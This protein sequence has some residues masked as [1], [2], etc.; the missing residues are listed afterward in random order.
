L[1]SFEHM[2]DTI[3]LINVSVNPHRNAH[4]KQIMNE[5]VKYPVRLNR[6]LTSVN[7]VEN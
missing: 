5:S 1:K 4:M 6:R 7:N 2:I 3:L